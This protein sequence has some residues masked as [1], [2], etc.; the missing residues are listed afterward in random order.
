M[1]IF[2]SYNIEKLD[3]ND[4]PKCNA[5]WDMQA[6]PLTE[7]F[8]KE[9]ES[10]N[11]E[12]YICKENGNFIGE[13]ACVYD[14]NDPD[15][16]ISGQRIYLSRLIVKPNYRNKGIGG[17]LIDFMIEKLKYNGYKEITVGVDKDNLAAI[18][19]YRKKGF[20]KVLFDGCDEQGEYFKLLK[21]L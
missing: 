14:M 17:I 16:T 3:I 8:R 13:I 7:K 5:I 4:Y 9:I 20:T 1:I 18:H 12:V 19:L 15:Y 21:T 11:R 2:M 10:G 6:D